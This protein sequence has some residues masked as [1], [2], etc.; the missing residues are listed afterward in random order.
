MTLTR[1]D[2]AKT[3]VAGAACAIL[4]SYARARG[5]DAEI[6]EMLMLGL[7]GDGPNA[8]WAQRLARQIEAGEVGGVV[9]L[10]HNFRSRDGVT[11][12]TRLFQNAGSGSEPLIA[13]DQEGGAVQRLGSKL[14]YASIPRARQV[15]REMST[16]E[17]RALY[18]DLAREVRRAGFNFNLAPVV[19]LELDPDNPVVGKWGRAWGS[20]PETVVRYAEAFLRAH[21]DVGV[22]CSLKHFPGHGTSSGDSHDG[23][24]DISKTWQQDE[25]V[26]FATL[27]QSGLA[28]SVMTAHLYHAQLSDDGHH[29]VTLSPL[30]IDGFLRARLGY[31]GVVITDDLD[32]GAIRNSYRLEEAVILAIEAGN[33]IIMLSN[34]AAPDENLPRR[35]IETVKAAIAEGRISGDR[36]AQS[37]ERIRRLK[38]TL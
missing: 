35:M 24:V 20:D 28:P 2:A 1:R 8:S 34:S 32:M 38:A 37:V 15:A 6:G 4:P 26:P 29:P 5:L 23:F 10:G 36:I 11:G 12:L 9:M 33:D 17:A 27:I 30:A 25:L 7:I 16:D 21:A 19:D 18:T 3:L 31:Q 13:L 14:G 22:A